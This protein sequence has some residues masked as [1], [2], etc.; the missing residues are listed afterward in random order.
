MLLLK[1]DV[2]AYFYYLNHFHWNKI[3]KR[4]DFPTYFTNAFFK[5]NHK[6][7]IFVETS[8][9]VEYSR[10]SPNFFLKSKC[11]IEQFYFLIHVN[12]TKIEKNIDP[13]YHPL[14]PSFWGGSDTLNR[15]DFGYVSRRMIFWMYDKSAGSADNNEKC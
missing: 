3:E 1:V 5:E 14:K 8:T 13:L 7:K 4:S 10:H 11:P 2:E 6:L 9:L 15:L 12:S